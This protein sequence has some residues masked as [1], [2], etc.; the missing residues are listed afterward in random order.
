[1]AQADAMAEEDVDRTSHEQAARMKRTWVN[2]LGGTVGGM[3]QAVTGHPLDTI[4]V[5][6]MENIA[7][8]ISKGCRELLIFAKS[9]FSRWSC[10]T[11][12]FQVRLQTGH[13][14]GPIECARKTVRVFACSSA[15]LFV[16]GI[17]IY[18]LFHT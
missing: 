16:L 17:F 14:H 3:L 18:E 6:R 10:H 9:S 8:R 4:K 13:F 11:S 7:K 12:I 15:W 5:S 2:L 1:M